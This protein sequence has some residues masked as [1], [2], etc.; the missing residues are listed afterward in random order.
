[1]GQELY[2]VADADSLFGSVTRGLLIHLDYA[3]LIRLRWSAE[4]LREMGEALLRTRRVRDAGHALAHIELMRGSLPNSEVARERVGRELLG[5]QVLVR[6]QKDAHV[7]ACAMA[8]RRLARAAGCPVILITK[9]L[10]DFRA[11]MLKNEGV[12][13]MHPDRFLST[14]FAQQAVA[15]A[16][17]F[18]DFRET[19]R[20]GDSATA[21]L[22]RLA[23]DG[24]VVTASMLSGAAQAGDIA[25]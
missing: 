18:S 14:L 25:L 11:L 23:K 16:E 21:L 3:E 6:S 1:M 13:L 20:S 15:V 5:A 24:Q 2:V 17:A 22:D 10:K 19:L 8:V 9:N 7:A 4:I 12:D